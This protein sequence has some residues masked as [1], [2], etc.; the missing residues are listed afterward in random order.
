MNTPKA[1]G[2]FSSPERWF[3]TRQSIASYHKFHGDE[4][5]AYY[6]LLC[7]SA[8]GLDIPPY[9]RIVKPED[10]A[11]CYRERIEYLN[12]LGGYCRPAIVEYMLNAGHYHVMAFDGDTEFFSD[13]DDIWQALATGSQAVATP[14]RLYAPP[15]DG[16][17]MCLEQFALCGNYNVGL[18]GFANTHDA[19]KFVAWWLKE[20]LDFPECNMSAGR[21]C[22]QGWYR[23]V[24]DYLDDVYICRDQGINYAFWRYDTPGD[25]MHGDDGYMVWNA[26]ADEYVPLRMF[27]YGALDFNNLQR[28]AIHHNRCE[29][30]PG[31]MHLFEGYRSRVLA[32]T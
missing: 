29:A 7:G 8:D 25:V 9:V 15:R 10:T 22:E 11:G 16:K 18:T 23:F 12:P 31:L 4:D 24:G 6:V 21:F 17:V 20:T 28:V 13:I 3:Q 27:H 26:Q 32:A 5:T 14:H 19:R 2:W 1:V 30:G